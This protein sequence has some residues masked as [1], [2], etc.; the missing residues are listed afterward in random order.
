MLFFK[1]KKRGAT[2]NANEDETRS[3]EIILPIVLPM[4]R[5]NKERSST[6]SA[7]H[8]VELRI[9]TLTSELDAT[10]VKLGR[11]SVIDGAQIAC[12]Y[13]QSKEIS[14][15]VVKECDTLRQMREADENCK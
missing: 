15:S 7:S 12:L 3:A 2:L 5:R 10:I 8:V 13:Q 6:L 4:F 9:A 11:C 14:A 1:S